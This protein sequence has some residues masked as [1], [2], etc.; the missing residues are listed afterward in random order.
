M[1]GRIEVN[2]QPEEV[3]RDTVQLHG[4]SRVVPGAKGELQRCAEDPES[5]R[6]RSACCGDKVSSCGWAL[7]VGSEHRCVSRYPDAVQRHPAIE[8]AN[9]EKDGQSDLHHTDEL[10]GERHAGFGIHEDAFLHGNAG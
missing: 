8:E 7:L 4:A 9:R 10:A 6:V 2:E 1:V 3:H 5:P